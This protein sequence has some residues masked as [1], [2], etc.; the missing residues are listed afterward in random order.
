MSTSV[1]TQNCGIPFPFQVTAFYTYIQ[2][3][4]QWRCDPSGRMPTVLT[5]PVGSHF[6]KY[7]I[8]EIFVAGRLLGAHCATRTCIRRAK[9]GWT[10][11][12][13]IYGRNSMRCMESPITWIWILRLIA[14]VRPW[15]RGVTSQLGFG[16]ACRNSFQ[17]P[18]LGFPTIRNGSTS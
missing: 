13:W 5:V 12:W 9:Y 4:K 15:N 16:L 10:L 17:V 18:S 8:R 11:T 1:A 2:V 3:G 6:A 14:G 7:V